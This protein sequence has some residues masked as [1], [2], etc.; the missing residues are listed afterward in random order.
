MRP[1]HERMPVI[2]P[3]ETFTAWLN[4]LPLPREILDYYLKPYISKNMTAWPVSTAV[5]KTTNQGEQLIH[6]ITANI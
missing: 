2:L 5:N 1:I 6:P 3:P 4:P